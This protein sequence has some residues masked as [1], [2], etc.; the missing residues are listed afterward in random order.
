[1]WHFEN[2]F[3]PLNGRFSGYQ[4]GKSNFHFNFLN[5]NIFVEILGNS[6]TYIWD[7]EITFEILRNTEL[8]F[9]ASDF[10]S[11]QPNFP[12]F[13]IFNY[14]I[15]LQPNFPN[16]LIINFPKVNFHNFWLILWKIFT[17]FMKLSCY[18][19]SRILKLPQSI[20][21]KYKYRKDLK[22]TKNS[23]QKSS[24]DVSNFIFFIRSKHQKL[25]I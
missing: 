24:F 23:T 6:C 16:F 1:M 5:C 20:L 22:L 15:F 18:Q 3:R 7:N 10:S 11:F 17:E 25:C 14:Q 8:V 12:I 19:G 21:M 9:H 4:Q 13:P 2:H